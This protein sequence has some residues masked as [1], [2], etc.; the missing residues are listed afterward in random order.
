[1]KTNYTIKNFAKRVMM[2][3]TIVLFAG[4]AWGYTTGTLPM[5][6]SVSTGYT[7]NTVTFTWSSA[8]IAIRKWSNNKSVCRL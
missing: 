2:A 1:M 5:N 8:N 6:T 7:S 3:I 4:N